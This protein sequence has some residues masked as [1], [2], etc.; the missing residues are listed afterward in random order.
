MNA[1]KGKINPDNLH[2]NLSLYRRIFTN[3][4]DCIAILNPEGEYVEQNSAH[5]KLFGLT[6]FDIMG[7]TPSVIIGKKRFKGILDSLKEK[8]TYTGEVTAADKN[9]DEFTTTL[10]AFALRKNGLKPTNY[11]YILR[12]ITKGEHA[13]IELKK[14][15]NKYRQLVEN[16]LQA[17][18]IIQDFKIVYTNKSFSSIFGY[19]IDELLSFTPKE[20]M[21]IVHPDDQELVWGNLK[22]RLVGLDI[23]PHYQFKGVSKDGR[24]KILDLFASKTEF[25]GKPAIQGFLIDITDQ[26]EAQENIKKRTKFIETILNNLPLGIAVNEIN[27]GKSTFVNKEFQEISGWTKEKIQ[28]V[29]KFFEK[30][31]N[32]PEQGKDISNKIKSDIKDKKPENLFW[33]SIEL[34][35][36]TGDKRYLSTKTIPLYDQ[37]LIILT[38]QDITERI[39]A[40]KQI[41]SSLKEKEILLRE[42][43]HRVKNNLQTISSLL[44]LQAE[45]IK[46]PAALGAFRSSQSRIRSMALIHERLYKSK[47]L[48]RIKAQEYLINLIDYLEA[49]YDSQAGNIKLKTNVQNIM[50]NIDTAIP[51][52][53]IVN[54][55]VSNS[56]KYA[57]PGKQAGTIEVSL[58]VSSNNIISL[59]VKDDGIGIPADITIENSA[60]LG[61]QLVHLLAK[62]IYGTLKTERKNGTRVEIMFPKSTLFEKI[63]DE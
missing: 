47:D 13:D 56:M 59:C 46:D 23:P 37:D 54:E 9:G 21:N 36:K 33:D 42:I 4:Y 3:S 40:D 57:F 34:E 7:E 18:V 38:V 51:C 2:Q 44:D 35:S 27:S 31:L 50:L 45:S 20:T 41:Q 43:H 10:S 8:G 61:L 63:I 14:S 48:S 58:L 1:G 55:L 49:T 15:E 52:G 16:S 26:V 22:K 29:R 60:S 62:Q 24:T 53:L 25:E 11:V 6:D 30:T 17:I 12:N 5:Q 32:N 39:T 28:N 19:T